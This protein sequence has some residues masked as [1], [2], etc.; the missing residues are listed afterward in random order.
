MKLKKSKKIMAYSTKGGVGKSTSLLTIAKF[1]SK[2][3][4]KICLIDVDPQANLSKTILKEEVFK[5]DYISMTELFSSRVDCKKVHSAIYNVEENLDII[6]SSLSLVNSEQLVRSNT[7]CDQGRIISK[8]IQCIEDEYDIILLDFNPFPSL[9]TTNGFIAS[10]FVIIPT[11]CD[12]WAADGVA[13]TLSQIYQVIDGFGKKIKYKVL[14]N[15]KSRNKDD[16]AFEEDI[17]SQLDKRQLFETNI[18]FQA[19]PF[20]NKDICVTDFNNGN[21]TVGKEWLNVLNEIER[22]VLN[23]G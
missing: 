13:T 4:Y 23:N 21:T 5:D 17:K 14:I 2:K 11:T 1:F 6:G 12:E 19:K 3:G 15:Q 9:L 10:D 22:E 16:T 8:I 7:M 20:K 18:H